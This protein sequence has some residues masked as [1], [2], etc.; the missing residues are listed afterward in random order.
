MDDLKFIS[1]SMVFQSYKENGRII[2]IGCVQRNPVYIRK[3]FLFKL[4]LN[5]GPE[6]QQASN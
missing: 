3:N 6:K 1:F 5:P 4:K 2:M